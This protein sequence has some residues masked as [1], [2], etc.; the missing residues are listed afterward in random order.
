MLTVHGHM[1]DS[2][3]A[4]TGLDQDQEQHPDRQ[5]DQAA[6]FSSASQ[7]AV[8][9]LLM[10]L[11]T[12]RPS[13]QPDHADADDAMLRNETSSAWGPGQ[14]AQHQPATLSAAW[15][16]NVGIVSCGCHGA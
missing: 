7:P 1:Q 2:K 8:Q 14:Q 9:S 16:V 13:L 12:L 4:R 15:Q 5:A 6:G 10:Q 11:Q 3:K